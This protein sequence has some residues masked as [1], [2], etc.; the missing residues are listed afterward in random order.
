MLRTRVKCA[1]IMSILENE[2][3]QPESKKQV[4][5]YYVIKVQQTNP[6][7]EFQNG[8]QNWVMTTVDDTIVTVIGVCKLLGIYSLEIGS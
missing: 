3:S 6:N 7:E 1:L 5:K 2:T 8:I 4:T